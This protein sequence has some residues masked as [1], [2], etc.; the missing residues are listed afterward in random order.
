MNTSQYEQ[1]LTFYMG[2]LAEIYTKIVNNPTDKKERE[3]LATDL[4]DYAMLIS[5]TLTGSNSNKLKDLQFEISKLE[6]ENKELTENLNLCRASRMHDYNNQFSDGVKIKN[7]IDS[8][9]QGIMYYKESEKCIGDGDKVI[10]W[11]NFIAEGLKSKDVCV[12]KESK[13]ISMSSVTIKNGKLSYDKSVLKYVEDCKNPLTIL[14]LSLK[15]GFLVGHANIIFINKIDKTYERFDP[16]GEFPTFDEFADPCMET[17]FKTEFKLENYT[18]IKPSLLCPIGPQQVAYIGDVKKCKNGGYC[19]VF[20]MIYAHLKI[21]L[22]FI[23]SEKILDS[24]MSWQP[25]MLNIMMRKY[26]TWV[27]HVLP[28]KLYND[29]IHM[30]VGKTKN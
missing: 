18:Y 7:A 26:I 8:I 1:Y 10:P 27:D 19:V 13:F 15:K 5:N 28:D 21:L 11:L 14:F 17:S 9:Y 29:F 24:W 2:K 20:S 16:N 12:P 6:I 4:E 22:P 25:N 3:T 23:K 30:F